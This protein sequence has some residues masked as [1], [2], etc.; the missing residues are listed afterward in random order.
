MDKPKCSQCLVCSTTINSTRFG[1]D[2]CSN[3]YSITTI[4]ACSSFFKRKKI[5]R[6][7]ELYAV[8]QATCMDIYRIFIKE[9]SLFFNNPI[10]PE[11]DKMGMVE[12]LQRTLQLWGGIEKYQMFS[13]MTCY[14]VEQLPLNSSEENANSLARS[15]K[16]YADDQL[17]ILIPIFNKCSFTDQE[18]YAL[19][20]LVMSELDVKDELTEKAELI[21]DKYRQETLQDLQLHYQKDFRESSSLFKQFYRF[22]STVFDVFTTEN[23]IRYKLPS[24]INLFGCFSKRGKLHERMIVSS[25]CEQC[26]VCSAPITSVHLGMDI[27]RA[28]SCFFKRS[29]TMGRQYPCRIG[30]GKCSIAK[31]GKFA[32][33]GCRLDKCIEVGIAYDGPLR[34][35]KKPVFILQR[36]KTE[37]KSSVERRRELELNMIRAHGGHTRYPHQTLELYDMHPDTIMH[38]Y[39][40]SI[41][42]SY[43]FFRNV[44]PAFSQLNNTEIMAIF[45]DY[46]DVFLAIYNKCSI[47]EREYHALLG[48][49]MCELDRACEISEEAQI[50]IDQYRNEILDDLQSYYRNEL[51]LTD[52][53]T[54]LGN[55]MSLNHAI[56]EC[57][58]LMKGFFTF[59][60]TIFDVF[61]ANHLIKEFFL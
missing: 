14:D 4:R 6:K 9:S 61:M 44:F 20:A 8:H 57:K 13:V 36:I 19:M 3:F 41:E 51:G 21:I 16:S 40:I 17:E 55:L 29:I 34:V 37:S 27:C 26:L 22:Y 11:R 15:S 33:R 58:S 18:F 2:V 42:E 24:V 60:T 54:R 38:L 53:S 25:S 43:V 49:L 39:R 12:G 23:V 31:D 56:Q 32:C 1:M 45:K 47:T 50:I 35:R 10:L 52:F 5:S 28:C 30:D 59:Y 48:L 7:K 46:N